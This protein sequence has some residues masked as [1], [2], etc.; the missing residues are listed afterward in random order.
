MK[1]FKEMRE[2]KHKEGSHVL[3]AKI[4]MADPNMLLRDPVMYRIINK[5]T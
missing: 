1:I 2:G 3:R 4:D 5:T